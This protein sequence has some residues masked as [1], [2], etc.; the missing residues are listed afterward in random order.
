MNDIYFFT[1]AQRTDVDPGPPVLR[2]A[3]LTGRCPLCCSHSP[4]RHSVR[5]SSQSHA[6][7]TV[8]YMLRHP[9]P[10]CILM[11]CCATIAVSVA[12]ALEMVP[13]I[14]FK[15]VLIK[16]MKGLPR[17]KLSLVAC[18]LTN[19]VL[20]RLK[21]QRST[22]WLKKKEGKRA[23][24]KEMSLVAH[25]STQCLISWPL[26]Q[27]CQI[28]VIHL[29]RRDKSQQLTSLS[30][31]PESLLGFLHTENK[32]AKKTQRK[33]QLNSSAQSKVSSYFS[34][35]SFHQTIETDITG[36]LHF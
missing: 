31:V 15:I 20:H 3:V 5:L 35:Y 29:C 30:P 18:C 9:G 25:N 24:Q 11:Y 10:S 14:I 8:S 28:L 33:E 4:L 19:F 2:T 27:H 13:Y 17:S 34:S 26:I 22:L 21:Q 16:F 12:S 23:A 1:L 36:C 6:V 7:V 32:A